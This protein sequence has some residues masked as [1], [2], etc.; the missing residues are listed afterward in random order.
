MLTTAVVSSAWSWP[1]PMTMGPPLPVE[2]LVPATSNDGLYAASALPP[3]ASAR[4]HADRSRTKRIDLV[5]ETPF[6]WGE[7][8]IGRISCGF[9]PRP[10]AE[11]SEWSAGRQEAAERYPLPFR[12]EPEELRPGD[13]EVVAGRGADRDA[14]EQEGVVGLV[15]VGDRPLEPRPAQIPARLAECVHHRVR[16][17]HPVEVVDVAR[18]PAREV[19]AHDPAV[20]ANGRIAAPGRR[21]RVLEVAHADRPRRGRRARVQADHFH[22]RRFDRD[23][24]DKGARPP[25]L[26][27]SRKERLDREAGCREE[28][29]RVRARPLQLGDLGVDVRVRDLVAAHGDDAARASAEPPPQA[30][31]QVSTV[32]GVLVEHGDSRARHRGGDVAPVDR[33]LAHEAREVAHRPRVLAAL[34]LERARARAGEDVRD[35]DLVQIGANGDRVFRADRVEDREDAVLLDEPAGLLDGAADLEA[36]VHVLVPDLPAEDASAVVDVAEVGVRARCDGG[37]R[38]GRPCERHGPADE[39]RVACH[40]GIGGGA[41][42]GARQRDERREG[43]DDECRSQ[44]ETGRRR[45]GTTNL[46]SPRETRDV[47]SGPVRYRRLLGFWAV[48]TPA[49]VN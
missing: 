21:R 28:H 16:D 18:L 24:A 13:R 27:V 25:G 3:K 6:Q 4:A 29:E 9:L 15:Q 39:D 11:S 1:T 43:E 41:G 37:E 14:G 49:R 26:A 8:E 7:T 5:K 22:D 12:A 20:K 19:A 47:A 38:R 34:S 35:A 40:A 17:G 33:A 46:A 48:E 44:R 30:V 42:V 31:R 36:V 32:V 2:W 10:A 45:T 23:G